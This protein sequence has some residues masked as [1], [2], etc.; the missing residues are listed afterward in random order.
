M[1]DS[2][3]TDDNKQIVIFFKTPNESNHEE[4]EYHKLFDQTNLYTPI[5]ISI[6]RTT[7]EDDHV[8]E[9]KT[10]IKLGA[11]KLHLDGVIITSSRSVDSFQLALDRI[12]Q[13]FDEEDDRY[14]RNDRLDTS[15]QPLGETNS[16][17]RDSDWCSI[18]FFVIGTS[19]HR[20]LRN[21]NNFNDSR[22][23][24]NPRDDQL[25]I[26]GHDQSGSGSKLAAFIRSYFSNRSPRPQP[27]PIRLDEVDEVELGS[28]DP[29]RVNLLYLTGNH[30]D[31]SLTEALSDHHK[32][33]E[34][35][36][37]FE[38]IKKIVYSVEPELEPRFEPRRVFEVIDLTPIEIEVQERL[39][40]E[41]EE[42]LEE[43]KL[44]HSPN[45]HDPDVLHS[46]H[47]A[48][49]QNW[50]V[51]F[52]PN[53]T[54]IVLENVNNLLVKIKWRFSSLT[55][56]PTRSDVHPLTGTLN[57]DS[58]F[59]LSSFKIGAIGPTTSNFLIHHFNINPHVTSSKP[60]AAS[61]L[62]SIIDSDQGC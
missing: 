21:L 29:L 3:R 35:K 55:K 41:I 58:S 17:I 33:P 15:A 59:H 16:L 53:T 25:N 34:Y 57:P 31:P 11:Q 32:D 19:T 9:L 8:N 49:L 40:R 48:T 28:R 23:F 52:S 38:L 45:D 61:L 44:S 54:R 36:I 13:E 22:V 24:P 39:E 56:I 26:L 60:N 7:I 12:K 30:V 62:K 6:L 20:N 47:S 18:P 51:F 37:R 4:D 1:E 46:N 14:K 43:I 10:I 27:R 5:F 42:E 2:Q 50:I